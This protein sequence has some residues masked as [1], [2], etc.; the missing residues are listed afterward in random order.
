[1]VIIARVLLVSDD[2]LLNK[3]P[4]K[5]VKM[6]GC[7]DLQRVQVWTAPH[8]SVNGPFQNIER[9]GQISIF[10]RGTDEEHM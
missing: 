4:N 1:M 10:I 3:T 6:Y 7:L 5:E 2:L 8:R 9:A